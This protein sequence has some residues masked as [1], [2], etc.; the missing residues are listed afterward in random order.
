VFWTDAELGV[1][2]TEAL[3]TFGVLSGYWRARGQFATS[4]G[5]AFY[6]LS[7]Q[8]SSLI[9]QTVTDQN[10]VTSIQYHLLEPATG[11]SWTGTEQFT[12]ADVTNALEKRL[13]QFILETGQNEGHTTQVAP[14]SPSG[15][16]TLTDTVMEVRR[17]VWIPLSGKYV[18]L[19]R[20]DEVSYG[21]YD[22]NWS[23][24][25]GTPGSY[26]VLAVNPLEIQLS[27]PNNDAGTLDLLT[28]NSHAALNPASGVT[29]TLQDDWT[30]VIKWGALAELLSRDGQ[31]R[32]PQ[33]AEYCEAMYK[34]G[35]QMAQEHSSVV[36]CQINGVPVR[37]TSLNDMDAYT[38][39]WQG[40]STGTPTDL[41]FTSDFAVLRPVPDGAYSVVLDVIRNAPIPAS[42]SANVQL[43]REQL[44]AILDYGEH[45]A[46]FKM[47]GM[48][49]EIT[50][51]LLQNFMA[52]AAEYNH[53]VA[54]AARYVIPAKDQQ[55]EEGYVR[56]TKVRAEGTGVA[57]G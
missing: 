21:G 23:V 48:E 46:A 25:G 37:A 8:L 54:A 43:G 18:Q 49:F 2:L 52:Q 3:R 6:D 4:S 51:R 22:T 47:G 10:L 26:S 34:A 44:D 57:H 36:S 12:L 14:A 28:V 30:W 55:R 15:R 19:W 35:T 9:G 45:L 42:D 17:L 56:P 27:P 20:S 11:S 13:N 29:L 39:G 40:R 16:V 24:T 31:A 53:H 1:Y 50:M 38:P 41:A 33:R 7:S 5:T 32:D